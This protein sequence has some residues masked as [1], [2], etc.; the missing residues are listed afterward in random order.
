[1][2]RGLA[3]LYLEHQF[4]NPCRG[5]VTMTYADA[6][7]REVASSKT[8]GNSCFTFAQLNGFLEGRLTYCVSFTRALQ[9]RSVQAEHFCAVPNSTC[10]FTIYSHSPI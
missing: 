9:T 2:K 8:G 6:H 5:L 10:R 7:V 3:P 1:M 4:L